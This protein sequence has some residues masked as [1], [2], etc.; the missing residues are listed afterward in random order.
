[1][2]KTTLIDMLPLLIEP[3]KGNIT[4]DNLDTKLIDI[5]SLREFAYV[6]QNHFSSKG[7]YGKSKLLS[8]Y[9]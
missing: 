7:H 6:D 4:V 9:C 3:T 1:M 8:K 5:N 2:G